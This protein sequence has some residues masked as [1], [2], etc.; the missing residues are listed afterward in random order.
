[1]KK[2]NKWFS[3]IEILVWMFIFTMWLI[4]VFAL[5]NHSMKLNDYSKKSI[6]ATSLARENIEL[7][8]NQRDINYFQTKMWND[9]IIPDWFEYWNKIIVSQDNWNIIIKK[10][11]LEKPQLYLNYYN[12][13]WNLVENPA[14]NEKKSL[15]L[16][17]DYKTSW[18]KS[19]YYSYIKISKINDKDTKEA[20]RLESVVWWNQHEVKLNTIL[21]DWTQ[22]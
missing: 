3:I 21:T 1:M 19:F 17:Y 2:N 6:I 18:K 5:I 11:T 15:I 13:D 9:W 4:S 22:R 12:K 20:I 8:K 10:A 7:I 14:E 16:K